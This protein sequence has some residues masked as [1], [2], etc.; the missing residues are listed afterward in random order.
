MGCDAVQSGVSSLTF[1]RKE[2][3]RMSCIWNQRTKEKSNWSG[4]HDRHT[5]Y[6]G[7]TFLRNARELIPGFETMIVI[8]TAVG[9]SN[10]RSFY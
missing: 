8:C 2:A 4:M 10:L 5:E 1:Q 9:T 7:S 6:G 3:S